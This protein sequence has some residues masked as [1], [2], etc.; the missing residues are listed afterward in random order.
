MNIKRYFYNILLSIYNRKKDSFFLLIIFMVMTIIIFIFYGFSI[1]SKMITNRID[2]NA[3]VNITI[4]AHIRDDLDEAT[5][6]NSIATWLEA[7][8][9]LVNNNYH[10]TLVIN[11]EGNLDGKTINIYSFDEKFYEE[12]NKTIEGAQIPHDNDILIVEN[13]IIHNE[14]L[15]IGDDIVLTNNDGRII[16]LNVSGI[17]S[18]DNTVNL[19]ED[20]LYQSDAYQIIMDEKTLLDFISKNDEL[21]IGDIM[22]EFKGID[23]SDEISDIVNNSLSSF[24]AKS[25][26]YEMEIDD[27]LAQKLKLPIHNASNLYGLM[28]TVFFIALTILLIFVLVYCVKNRIKEYGIWMAMGLSK[29]SLL[30]KF[31]MEI[32]ILMSISYIICLPLSKIIFRQINNLMIE[33]NDYT[34]AQILH[35]YDT[36]GDMQILE[37]DEYLVE[38]E[39]E[40]YIKIYGFLLAVC[41]SS[42][43]ISFISLFNK[44]VIEFIK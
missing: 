22:V 30:I 24:I 37:S 27:E 18:K 7:N 28:A 44:K 38:I 26:T 25:N 31:F 10:S 3:N 19:L 20:S 40:D 11:T 12:G 41:L 17:Y 34:Q 39:S 29:K 36:E 43:L 1:S 6:K 9:E 32:S 35:L 33:Q 8:D 13:T 42:S 2:D 5:Y 15:N 23:N 14:L 4:K 21:I 16:E